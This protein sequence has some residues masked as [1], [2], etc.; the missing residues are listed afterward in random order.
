MTSP[1]TAVGRFRVGRKHSMKK[2]RR[3][4]RYILAA[5]SSIGFVL[6]LSL[7][8]TRYL[9]TPGLSIRNNRIISKTFTEKKI[10]LP[11]RPFNDLTAGGIQAKLSLS[12]DLFQVTL[13]VSAAL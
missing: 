11:G 8:T 12:T 13:L 6:M 3:T 2:R 7:T 9:T 1:P 4:L 5:S 10:T